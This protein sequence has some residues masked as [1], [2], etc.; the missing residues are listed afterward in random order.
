MRCGAP[1]PVVADHGADRS[2]LCL[3]C[4][5]ALIFNAIFSM[6]ITKYSGLR[7]CL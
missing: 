5:Q 1:E 4:H 2:K 3:S 7:R 6:A